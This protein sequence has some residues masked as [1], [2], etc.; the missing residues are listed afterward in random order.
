MTSL[1]DQSHM[2]LDDEASV[3]SPDLG[4]EN[5]QDDGSAVASEN[6]LE[7]DQQMVDHGTSALAAAA[8]IDQPLPADVQKHAGNDQPIVDMV[9][10]ETLA[11]A[12]SRKRRCASPA[13]VVPST[14][15]A[16]AVNLKQNNK[17]AKT[18]SSVAALT[19]SSQ[20]LQGRATRSI[21]KLH[22]TD[23]ATQL[24]KV[25]FR[26]ATTELKRRVLKPTLDELHHNAVLAAK[27]VRD[28]TLTPRSSF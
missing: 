14:P 4:C 2:L 28:I 9:K 27:L 17:R 12:S 18:M 7:E 25:F 22:D 16:P 6:L 20:K 5:D 13:A 3:S 11:V 8:S 21:S 1:S 15:S 10:A 24:L 26:D 23:A 19:L